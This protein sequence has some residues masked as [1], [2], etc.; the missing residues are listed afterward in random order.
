MD[1]TGVDKGRYVDRAMEGFLDSDGVYVLFS[2]LGSVVVT[3]EKK[4][5][6][7]YKINV[8]LILEKILKVRNSCLDEEYF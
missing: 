7:L 6:L 1:W 5:L 8:V 3:Y 4:R 2:S